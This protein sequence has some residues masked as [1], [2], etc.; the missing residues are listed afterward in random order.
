MNPSA[1]RRTLWLALGT[2]VLLGAS[3]LLGRY[4]HPGWLAPSR[5]LQDPLAWRLFWDLRLPRVLAALTTGAALA[6]SGF[7]LQMLFRNPL[8]EP[9]FLGVSQGAAFGAALVIL[10][11][12]GH[13]LAVQAGA[14]LMGLAALGLSEAL[15]RRLRYGGWVLRMVLAGIAVSALFA[16]GLG[17]LKYLADPLS[18]LP[19]IVFWL[20][21]GLWGTRWTSLI[22]V[23]LLAWP[24]LGGLYLLR[25]R[26]NV[27]ALHRE[28]AFS[29]GVNPR[30]ERA[31]LL[32][33]AVVA[34]AAVVSLA[35]VI[36]WV[37]LMTP[38]LARRWFGA[39]AR[40]ALPAAMLL[41]ALF[42]L[43]CDDLARLL[44]PGELPLGL[45]T[46]LLGAS[47]LIAL[48]SAPPSPGEAPGHG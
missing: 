10:T 39:D 3:L 34:T 23:L 9:G 33:L 36:G 38:H 37:G 46:A 15:A 18:Q 30:R 21:G 25:W 6:G 31:L 20:L 45:L 42:T 40:Q 17:L 44:T 1:P 7:T 41:G 13:P 47:A 2:L 5:L 4:P 28:T 27:L 11:L 14:A 29:L 12:G 19:E 35:G 16:A 8:V 32:T 24:A 26:L 43:G 48:L 22:P